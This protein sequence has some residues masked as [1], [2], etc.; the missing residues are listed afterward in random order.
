M[1]MIPTTCVTLLPVV[2]CA[3]GEATIEPLT[4]HAL[5]SAVIDSGPP[6]YVTDLTMHVGDSVSESHASAVN[7]LP[8]PV[9]LLF[10]ITQTG[11]TRQKTP[12]HHVLRQRPL[13]RE[14]V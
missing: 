7:L 3:S 4:L 2:F 10:Q 6:A 14:R 8:D 9:R 13:R 12:A 1:P 11:P 5:A